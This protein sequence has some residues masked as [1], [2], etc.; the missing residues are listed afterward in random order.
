MS[1]TI[2]TNNPTLYFGYSGDQTAT[3]TAKPTGGTAPYRVSITMVDPLP[4]AQPR[5]IERMGGKLICDYINTAGDEVWTPGANTS[6]T[7]GNS[8]NSQPTSTSNATVPSGG[9]YSVNVTLLT[10][11][12]FVATITDANGCSYTIPYSQSVAVDAEDVRCF[13]GNSNVVKVTLCH[14]TG[15]A[16]NPCVT[17]CVD[18]SA[19]QEHLLLHGDFLG[20]CNTTCTAPVVNA[21]P[22]P[23]ILAPVFASELTVKVMPNPTPNYFNVAIT[24]KNN[25]PVTVRVMDIYGRTLQLNQKIAANSTLRLGQKWTGGTY[26]IEVIQGDE[27]KVVKVIKAN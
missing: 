14:R 27:R 25:T 21:K 5:P 11:A 13:A 19:V 9:S 3:I 10:D 8:C 7:T 16:K 12:R 15:S 23:V 24:G 1:A 6:T 4:A 18:G 20:K 22:V 26:L 2:A 17:I